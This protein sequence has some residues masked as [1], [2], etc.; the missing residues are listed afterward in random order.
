M[1]RHWPGRRWMER[2]WIEGLW[3]DWR[4]L[5]ILGM[6]LAASLALLAHGPI[7]QDASYHAFADERNYGGIPNTV[8]TLS[9]LA[10]LL[11]GLAGL[12]ALRRG[13]PAGGL[14]SLRPAYALFFAG[15]ALLFP[16]SGFYHLWPNN[17][18]LAWD[19]LAMTISFMAFFASILGEHVSPRLGLRLLLPLILL[20]I[21]SVVYWRLSD[22]GDGGDLR[23]YILVQFLPMLL[24]PFILLTFPGRLRPMG[25]LWAVIGWYVLA[26][27]LEGLDAPI[28]HLTGLVSGHSLK[29]LAAALGI[30]CFL[31]ALYRRRPAPSGD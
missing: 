27:G 16:T 15:A 25:Y 17:A 20:G 5:A 11:V 4:G 14:A 19:R 1:D 28:L 8:D 26:K 12:F 9:N 10:F 18:G 30:A 7:Y 23:L 3:A 2:R 24:V 6:T 21:L 13:V 22:S 31:V 29:H